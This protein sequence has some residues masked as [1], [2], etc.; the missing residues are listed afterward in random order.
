YDIQSMV[1]VLRIRLREILR[2]DMGGTYGVGV[3]SSTSHYPD[4]EYELTISFGCDPKRAEELV[5][6]VLDEIAVFTSEETDETYL[7]KVKESQRRQRET[8]IKQNSFWLSNLNFYYFHGE[9]P[10]EILTL[11]K[12]IEKLSAG[13]VLSAAKQYFDMDNYVTVILYPEDE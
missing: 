10:G 4:E 9:D 7:N 11:D 6:T 12:Y 2:E 8:T 3:N 1:S 13:D 5:K